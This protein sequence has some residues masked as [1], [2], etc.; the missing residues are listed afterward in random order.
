MPF[1][2]LARDIVS[3]N[4]DV[5]HNLLTLVNIYFGENLKNESTYILS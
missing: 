4:A 1:D 3:W 5:D 2:C